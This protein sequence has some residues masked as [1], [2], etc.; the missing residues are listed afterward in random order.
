MINWQEQAKGRSRR[1]QTVKE[2]K[3]N[4]VLRHYDDDDDDD[5]DYKLRNN[6]LFVKLRVNKNVACHVV[7]NE[8][9]ISLFVIHFSNFR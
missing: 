3:E 6:S 4:S 5:D 8:L 7:L 9:G 2:V 1:I